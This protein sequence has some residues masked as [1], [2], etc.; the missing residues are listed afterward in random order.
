MQVIKRDGT[1]VPFRTRKIENAIRKAG[2]VD[3]ATVKNVSRTIYE[4]A[5]EVE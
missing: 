3:G 5:S 2:W 4:K 1:K